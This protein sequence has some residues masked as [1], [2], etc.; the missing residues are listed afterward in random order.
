MRLPRRWCSSSA[1]HRGAPMSMRSNALLPVL[2]V[3]AVLTAHA[4]DARADLMTA[5]ASESSR[6]C[7]NVSKGRGRISACLVGQMGQL[8]PA[9]LPEV[10]AVGQSRLTP[11][12]V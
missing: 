11:G 12:Y 5:C 3:A 1:A 4:T 9:C 6:Y 2:A 10:Q 7:G 8:G